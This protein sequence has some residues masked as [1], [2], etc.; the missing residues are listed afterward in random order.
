MS[1]ATRHGRIPTRSASVGFAAVA[2]L[3]TL[4]AAPS[5]P[6]TAILPS[7]VA[8]TVPW[9]PDLPI[10]VEATVGEISI[11]GSD[12]PDLDI[13]V[14][15]AGRNATD[16][17]LPLVVDE[18]PDA[19]RVSAV[20]P[21]EATD[22]AIRSVMTILAPAKARFES[23]DLVEGRLSLSNLSG[24][25][26]ARVSR[27]DVTASRLS[28]RVRIETGIGDIELDRADLVPGGLIRLRAFNGHVTL[29]FARRPADARI[30]ALVLN[31]DIRSDIPLQRTDRFGPRFAET[32]LGR[33]APVVSLD[34]VTGTI[35]I[36][37][38]KS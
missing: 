26:S 33:G 8:R 16:A 7:R 3:V 30:L 34:V 38:P 11:S 35:T 32:T 17:T 14:R 6:Q 19:V 37:A 10:F 22:P 5:P 20:Q 28:G 25:V 12:R 2:A 15:R 27:G 1:A 31:G 21:D 9:R 4:A 24:A 29:R 13:E 36:T 23:V 18:S